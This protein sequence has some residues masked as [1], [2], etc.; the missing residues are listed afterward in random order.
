ML[1]THEMDVV[2]R[3]C[4]R[5]AVLE[6]GRIVEQGPVAPRSSCI[7]SPTTRRFVLEASEHVDEGDQ[8]D[9]HAHVSGS[10]WRLTFLGEATYAPLLG[11]VA[12]QTS[13]TAS[14]PAAS[15]ASRTRPTAS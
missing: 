5:V 1:I 6:G 4:D 3:V 14:C 10:L 2:R 15:T 11:T 8:R 13:T 9:D 12:R 7:R